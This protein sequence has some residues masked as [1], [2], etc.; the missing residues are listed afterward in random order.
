[1]TEVVADYPMMTPF[2]DAVQ[3]HLEQAG[4]WQEGGRPRG[5]RRADRRVT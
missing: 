2:F 3:S 1:M 5:Q 4:E